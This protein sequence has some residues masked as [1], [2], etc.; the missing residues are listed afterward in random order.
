M[1]TTV[2]IPEQLLKRAIEET[3]I[4]QKTKLILS[5]LEALIEKKSRERLAHLFGS[6]S[7]AKAPRRKRDK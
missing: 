4:R 5:G 7:K 2:N 3:G 6:N 1:R